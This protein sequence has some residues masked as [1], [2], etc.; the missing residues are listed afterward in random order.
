MALDVV[1]GKQKKDHVKASQLGRLLAGT[2]GGGR[3]VLGTQEHMAATMQTANLVRIGTGD[4]VMDNRYITNEAYV[5][6]MVGSGQSGYNRND[7]VCVRYEKDGSGIE[8]ANLVVVKGT[9]TAGEAA[10]PPFAHGS[11]VDGDSLAEF[12]LWRLPIEGLNVRTPVPIFEELEPYAR[13]RES[14][15]ARIANLESS[16]DLRWQ[17]LWEG[18]WWAGKASDS[19]KAGSRTLTRSASGAKQLCFL[20]SLCEKTEGGTW[21]T[22]NT[23]WYSVVI[24]SMQWPW[25]AGHTFAYSYMRSDGGADWA[26]KYIYLYAD[27][28]V[29]YEMND[30]GSNR[31]CTLRGVYAIY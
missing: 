5:D 11:I 29:G 31:I 10:D 19:T 26:Y 14:A 27:R 1:Y 2:T 8:T 9:P 6:L 4:F 22:R 25:G 12:P 20:F 7:L 28:M 3:Y 30:E 15:L 23:G 24:P 16:H 21:V 13:F 18:D 17:T